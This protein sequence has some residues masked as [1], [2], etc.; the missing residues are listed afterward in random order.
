[1][2]P[3]SPFEA[4]QVKG[5]WVLKLKSGVALDYESLADGTTSVQV[6]ATDG[7]GL[8]KIETFT[9]QVSDIGL[10]FRRPPGDWTGRGGHYRTHHYTASSGC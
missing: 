7:A 9:I 10:P 6:K 8:T 4:V 3:S 1:M 2:D 5:N